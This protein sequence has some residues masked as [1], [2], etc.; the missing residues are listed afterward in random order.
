MVHALNDS[1]SLEGWDRRTANARPAS[2]LKPPLSE[3]YC[4]RQDLIQLR[5]TYKLIYI[6]RWLWI[7][8]SPAATSQVLELKAYSATP[9]NMQFW[10]F[11]YRVSCMLGKYSTHWAASKGTFLTQTLTMQLWLAL[12][13]LYN[14]LRTQ[15]L[16]CYYVWLF[17]CVPGI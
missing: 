6:R 17:I 8:D 16:N 11:Q 7:L 10:E 14:L 15:T 2:S 5:L 4:L 1:Y 9:D 12:N 3:F 13:S